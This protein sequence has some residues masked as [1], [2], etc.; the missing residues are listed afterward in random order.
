MLLIVDNPIFLSITVF[1]MIAFHFVLTKSCPIDSSSV[2]AYFNKVANL[3]LLP[4]CISICCI[5]YLWIWTNWF[6]WLQSPVLFLVWFESF[7]FLLIAW[8]FPF[9]DFDPFPVYSPSQ[10]N[11]LYHPWP[12]IDSWEPG[13]MTASLHWTLPSRPPL[14]LK[15]RRVACKI[16]E[17]LIFSVN[18]CNSV[19]LLV[20]CWISTWRYFSVVC[21]AKLC[22][23][24]PAGGF[25]F[26]SLV[27]WRC[28]AVVI[29]LEV[30]VI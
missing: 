13:I 12:P 28:D 26:L 5:L 7:P 24:L 8:T 15:H 21:G 30:L 6:H 22:W 27:A 18:I 11:V 9:F 20:T 1:V 3:I 23:S 17:E 25:R 29:T 4:S 14:R 19:Y 10:A 16:T 2:H